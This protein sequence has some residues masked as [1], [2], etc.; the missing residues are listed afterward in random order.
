MFARKLSVVA[1]DRAGAWTPV[2]LTWLD[3]FA[4]RN[5]TND[6]VFDD[7]LPVRD[8]V[9]EVGSRV[10]IATLEIAMESWFRRK[11]WLSEGEC[12]QVTEADGK[13]PC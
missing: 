9:L 8:G 5:F 12:L 6:A 2:P 11:G 1:Q 13:K 4:M 10:P 7:T 3:S